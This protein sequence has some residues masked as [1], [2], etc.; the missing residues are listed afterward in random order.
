MALTGCSKPDMNVIPAPGTVA[1]STTLNYLNNNFD[2]S[3]FAAAVDKSGLADSLASQ[4]ALYT[5]FAV[6]NNGFNKINVYKT[7]D[8]DAWGMDS[9]RIFIKMHMIPGRIDYTSIPRS[10]DTRYKNLNGDDL[11]V[12]VFETT[13][14][15]SLTVNGVMVSPVSI[16]NAP[17]GAAPSYGISLLNGIVYPINASLKASAENI[18]N[19]LA[20]KKDMTIFVA[21]LKKFGLWET[22]KEGTGITV[23]A[24]PDSVF[25]RY[26]I[27]LDSIG[28]MD[29]LRYKKVFMDTYIVRLNRIFL[30]DIYS[31]VNR[32]NVPEIPFK[33]YPML[34]LDAGDPN[35]VLCMLGN[36]TNLDFGCF[37]FD[38]SR[39]II[40]PGDGGGTYWFYQILGPNAGNPPRWDDPLSGYHVQ[41]LGESKTGG[42]IVGSCINYSLGNGALH[43]LNGLLLTPEDVKR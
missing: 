36:K 3:L 2:F 1:V 31:H 27:T 9:L 4:Q 22:V 33:V 13:S 35:L 30:S 10:L 16:L 43:L 40:M 17:S 26:G 18:Q 42:N 6:S 14:T 34:T 25:L 32:E 38:K 24:P 19:F 21:G 41:Y 39:L 29:T 23:L 28:K 15:V 8:F 37:V 7:T 12:S 20:S 5:V 11:F